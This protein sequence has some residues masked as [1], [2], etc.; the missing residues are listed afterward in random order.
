[1]D[2]ADLAALEH[3]NY[4]VAIEMVAGMRPDGVV[5]RQRGVAVLASGVALR[6]FN[7]VFVESD[8]ADVDG[9]A[10]AVAT[11]RSGRFRYVVDLRDGVDD[12]FAPLMA[13][14]GLVEHDD[15][16][17]QP[18]MALAP[19]R[20]GGPAPRELDIRLV[21][22]TPALD[23]HI[24]TVAAGF[25]LDE[26]LVRS[27]LDARLRDEPG[28]RFYVGYVD[29]EPVVSGLG[30]ATGRTIGVY[31]IATIESAR[32][33]GYGAAMTQRVGIDGRNAGCDVATLQASDMGRPI[34][35]RL[36]YRT[37]VRYRG[38]VDP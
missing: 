22:D 15:G 20:D 35:E 23:D 9:V 28:T 26:A 25:G 21:A 27:F 37:V 13:K 16:E 34:Y 36:G 32:R 5:R 11:M 33:R 31:N 38:F 4:I 8:E 12:R 10:D 3:E 18:G 17:P 19:I 1:V 29:G 30:V 14:L 2:D 6:L 7:Q 24:R